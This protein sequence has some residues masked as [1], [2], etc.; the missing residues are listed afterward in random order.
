[1]GLGVV[2]A[3]DMYLE[4][5]EGK[6][7]G[8]QK[9]KHPMSLRE[10]QSKLGVSLTTYHPRNRVLKGDEKLR[11]Y[12]QVPKEHRPPETPRKRTLEQ[13]ISREAYLAELATQ[14]GRKKDRFCPDANCLIYHMQHQ[15]PLPNPKNCAVCNQQCYTACGLCAGNDG[16]PLPLHFPNNRSKKSDGCCVI[17]Y[18]SKYYFGLCAKDLPLRGS[19]KSAWIAPTQAIYH[20]NKRAIEQY[21]NPTA[22]VAGAADDEDEETEEEEEVGEMYAV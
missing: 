6:L 22:Q 10:F 5:C 1:M 17:M 11:Q 14:A 18:H 19:P 2:T 3:Y 9:V 21:D 13:T 12:T 16:K 20:A 7:D 15:T 4:V 8:F